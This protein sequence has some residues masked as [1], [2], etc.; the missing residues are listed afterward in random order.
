MAERSYQT[1]R[2]KNNLVEV[3]KHIRR[4]HRQSNPLRNDTLIRVSQKAT[5]RCIPFGSIKK[6]KMCLG[7]TI[8]WLSHRLPPL[9]FKDQFPIQTASTHSEQECVM[10]HNRDWSTPSFNAYPLLKCEQ[11]ISIKGH[12]AEKVMFL[13]VLVLYSLFHVG[14]YSAELKQIF[15]IRI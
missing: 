6:H 11:N 7:R 5:K 12:E 3:G 10:N 14:Y 13:S 2:I 15:F 1:F 4:K 9:P 8:D